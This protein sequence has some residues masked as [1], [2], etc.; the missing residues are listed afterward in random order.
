MID[1][2]K[3]NKSIIPINYIIVVC[4]VFVMAVRGINMGIDFSGGVSMEIGVTKPVDLVA[5]KNALAVK[6][7]IQSIINS[8]NVII[9]FKIPPDMTAEECIAQ[10]KQQLTAL[11]GNVSYLRTD[12]VGPSIGRDLL[13]SGILATA[14]AML[15]I[16]LYLVIRFDLFFALGGVLALFN[17]VIVVLGFFSI[18]SMEFSVASI[19]A[20]LTIIGYSINDTVV[21]YDRIRENL[22]MHCKPYSIGEIINSSLNTVLRRT[23]MTS[24]TTLVAVVILIFFTHNTIAEFSWPML[25]G[26]V[27]GT[28]SSIFIAPMMPMRFLQQKA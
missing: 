26:I 22:N 1:F 8:N 6:S 17:D 16:F 2:L 3:L 12:Y 27:A 18:T 9:S 4:I 24:L 28:F 25:V 15:G 14:C 13:F 23:I 7:S 20:V 21:V 11:V 19:A 5:L 10:V